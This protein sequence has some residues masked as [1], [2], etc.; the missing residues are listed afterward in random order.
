MPLLD[1]DVKGNFK[2]G[3]HLFIK[4]I[5][6]ANILTGKEIIDLN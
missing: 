4:I 2:S 6:S 3:I 5:V 1:D